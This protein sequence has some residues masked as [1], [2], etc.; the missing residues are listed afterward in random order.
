V[1]CLRTNR[2]VW[3]LA[4]LSLWLRCGQ[5]EAEQAPA[6]RE[7]EVKAAFLFN[8]TRFVQ[9]PATAFASTNSPFVI[10]VVGDD[11]FGADLDDIVRGEIAHG[12]PLIVKRFGD[13]ED[14]SRCHLLFISRSKKEGLDLLLRRL[15]GQPVLTVGDTGGSAERGVMVN[16]LLVE[17]SIKMEINP[18]AAAEA[19]LQISSRLLS[20]AKIVDPVRDQNNPRRP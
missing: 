13:D 7:Y 2:A 20:L 9:W 15:A 19:G 11:P 8:F 1:I 6:P 4:L 5:V 18:K 16:L 3:W 14:L 17:G 12:H 10:G